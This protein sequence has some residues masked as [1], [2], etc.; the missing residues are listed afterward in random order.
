MKKI[1]NSFKVF[2]FYI[3]TL[4]VPFLI[5]VALCIF[6]CVFSWFVDKTIFHFIAI[7]F[8]AIVIFLIIFLLLS[9]FNK[10]LTFSFEKIREIIDYYGEFLLEKE[11]SFDDNT[12]KPLTTILIVL[13]CILSFLLGLSVVV[14]F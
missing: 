7:S 5:G 6:V 8:A 13:G 9:P 14:L 4:I 3:P 11:K 12:C 1:I 10:V 2:Y